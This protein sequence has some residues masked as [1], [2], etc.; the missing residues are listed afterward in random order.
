MAAAKY[1]TDNL[2][3]I[4]D[5]NR[6]QLDGLCED[7]MPMEDICDKFRAFGWVAMRIDGHEMEQILAGIEEANGVKGKPTCIVADTIKGKG[8]SYM[9]NVCDWHGKSPDEEQY[10]RAM[11]ELGLGN[12]ANR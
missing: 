10:A 5:R 8:I 2:V 9:E 3:A 11:K 1:K 12:Y 7:I 4:V 6:L